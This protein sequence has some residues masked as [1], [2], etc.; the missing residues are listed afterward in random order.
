MKRRSLWLVLLGG[1]LGAVWVGLAWQRDMRASHDLLAA[2]ADVVET[3]YGPLAFAS[4]G[5]GMPVLTIHGA[6]GGHDQ[7]RLLAEAFL[8]DGFGWIAPSRFGYPGSALSEDPS[9]AAQADAFAEMLDASGIERV[10][11]VAMSGGVPPALQFA[12]RHPDRTQALILLSL[13]PF[14]PLTAEEQELPVP[15]WLYD[16]LFATDFPLWALLRVAPRALDQMFDARPELVAQMSTQEAIFLDAMIAAFLP[17]TL[18]RAGLANEGAAI[19]P[20]AA[21]ELAAIGVPVLLVHARDDRLTP[22]STATFAARQ[23]AGAE[24]L[25]LDS[26]GHLLLGHHDA[27]RLRIHEFLVANVLPVAE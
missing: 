3:A 18:R 2:R 17:V 9:T 5:A 23:I 7:G 11:L 12:L 27:V 6:G 13:A 8:P 20:A 24:T 19:D 14:A 22:F 21:I 26:G 15:L 4:G 10:A 1:A 25:F 16:A